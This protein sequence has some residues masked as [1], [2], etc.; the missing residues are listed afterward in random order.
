MKGNCPRC[1]R[2]DVEGDLVLTGN[3]TYWGSD[4]EVFLCNKCME[5]LDE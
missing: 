2:T 4:E 5:E 3:Q 1:D